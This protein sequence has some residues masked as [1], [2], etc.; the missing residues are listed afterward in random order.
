VPELVA[1]LRAEH[2]RL[3]VRIANAAS[4]DVLEQ[5][6][7]GHFD[8]G[9]LYD[10]AVDTDTMNLQ[11]LYQERMSAYC[12]QRQAGRERITASELSQCHLIVPPRP[13]ALRRVIER[14]LPG[15]LTIA[16]ECNSISVSLDLAAKGVGTAVL[17]S[18]LPDHAISPRGLTRM[19][20]DG[21]NLQR[22]VVA[23][24]L[25]AAQASEATTFTLVAIMSLSLR[26]QALRA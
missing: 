25:A 16:V 24:H 14:E 17:P 20:I 11:R 6:A 21:A 19:E 12:L 22:E 9:L 4:P 13:Y 5:V 7:R 15:P 23:I 8:I 3:V 2:P 1:L 18:D 10:L 26:F